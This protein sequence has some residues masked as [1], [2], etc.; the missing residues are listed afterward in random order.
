LVSFAVAQ[1]SNLAYP[2][3]WAKIESW[4]TNHEN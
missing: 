4:A 2:V 1:V 3:V